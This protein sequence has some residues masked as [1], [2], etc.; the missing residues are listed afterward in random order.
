MARSKSLQD[1]SDS[2]SFSDGCGQTRMSEIEDAIKRYVKEFVWNLYKVFGK[3][4][5]FLYS[6]VSSP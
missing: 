6:A 5:K 4:G 1:F 2:G 3:K